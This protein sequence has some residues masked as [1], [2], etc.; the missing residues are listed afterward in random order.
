M[1]ELLQGKGKDSGCH[2]CVL[3]LLS[4]NVVF[5]TQSLIKLLFS[6]ACPRALLHASCIRVLHIN[7]QA[8]FRPEGRDY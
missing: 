3:W 6:S 8:L 7:L 1:G 2:L 5:E 4:A